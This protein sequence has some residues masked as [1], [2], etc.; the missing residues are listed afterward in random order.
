[1]GARI[2]RRSGWLGTLVAAV[3]LIAS[4]P[5]SGY[6]L[7]SAEATQALNLQRETNGLPGGITDRPEWDEACAA[8]LNWLALNPSAWT[9]NPHVEIPGTPGYTEAGAWAGL[10]SVLLGQL[11]LLSESPGW[12]DGWE[13]APYHLLHLLD[14]SLTE[15]GYMPNCV[16]LGALNRPAPTTTQILTYPGNETDFVRA[17]E[18]AEEWPDT[19][20]ARAGLPEGTI[21]GPYILVYAWGPPGNGEITAATLRGPTG[22]VEVRTISEPG[23]GGFL[24]PPVPLTVGATYAATVTYT[25]ASIEA[26]G[27]G[28]PPI[29]HEWSFTAARPG[30]VVEDPILGPPA[31]PPTSTSQP[32]AGS[33]TPRPSLHIHILRISR[34]MRHGTATI[35]LHLNTTAPG[36]ARLWGKGIRSVYGRF[37]GATSIKLKVIP[38]GEVAHMLR[39]GGKGR[40]RVHITIEQ[41][42]YAETTISRIVSLALSGP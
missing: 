8:H 20:A 39:R 9:T 5:A 42:G 3:C 2:R 31:A 10:H 12:Y 22:P 1:M 40:V 21:T 24:V 37:S 35:T 4:T 19:P 30:R 29:T 17:W 25:P 11:V 41:A 6:L 7:N 38:T 14:P 36:A 32:I 18:K 33:S 34:D 27:S 13:E 15:I 26:G 28:G 23:L 16:A